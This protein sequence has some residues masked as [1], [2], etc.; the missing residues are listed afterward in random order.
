MSISM[1]NIQYTVWKLK[2]AC[3]IIHAQYTYWT[4]YTLY[5]PYIYRK[6]Y[7]GCTWFTYCSSFQVKKS[8]EINIYLYLPHLIGLQIDIWHKNKPK[9]HETLSY[10]KH[11][12]FKQSSLV[13]WFCFH[14]LTSNNKTY[15]FWSARPLYNTAFGL[16]HQHW[17]ATFSADGVD[18]ILF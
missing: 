13:F 3:L 2:Y 1:M 17:S 10:K 6:P 7:P 11:S 4:L 18:Q 16:L 5:I 12:V 9:A 14:N 15:H 8:K